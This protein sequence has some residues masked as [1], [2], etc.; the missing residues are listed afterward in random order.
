MLISLTH[1]G[2]WEMHSPAFPPNQEVKARSS[3][4]KTK[5]GHIAKISKYTYDVYTHMQ[6]LPRGREEGCRA[7]D[8]LQ[9]GSAGP[10]PEG[11]G[12]HLNAGLLHSAEG[13]V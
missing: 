5:L 10:S 12:D 9:E 7:M 2:F 1:L 3:E 11:W 13:Q 6:L 4:F 8:V